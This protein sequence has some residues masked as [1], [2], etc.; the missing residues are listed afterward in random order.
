MVLS[1]DVLYVLKKLT[2][3]QPYNRLV[4]LIKYKK[5]IRSVTAFLQ[6]S[7]DDLVGKL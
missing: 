3:N 7:I 5:Y 1:D 2:L 4:I 6:Y